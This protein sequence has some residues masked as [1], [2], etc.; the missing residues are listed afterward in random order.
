[1]DDSKIIELYLMRDESAI[2]ETDR[3]YGAYCYT[4]ADNVLKNACDSKECVNDTWLKA[5]NSIPPKRPKYLNMFLA[6]ITRNLAFNMYEKRHAQ[7]RGSGE[8]NIV[9]DELAECIPA[10]SSVESDI[11]ANELKNCIN[12]YILS[13]PQKEAYIFIRRY[14]FTESIAQIAVK[15]NMS[16]NNVNVVLSRVRKKLKRHLAKEDYKL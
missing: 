12:S 8:I 5:W 11:L 6:K 3:K 4:V 9:L 10:G 15:Y 2:T 1:M 16:A 14:F 7:K 13:L